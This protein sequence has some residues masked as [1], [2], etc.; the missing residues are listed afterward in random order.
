MNQSFFI[1]ASFIFYETLVED[2]FLTI[3]FNYNLKTDFWGSD[4]FLNW[5]TSFMNLTWLYDSMV[6]NTMANLHSTMAQIVLFFWQ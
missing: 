6:Y 1:L 3:S 2:Y 5:K 4:F